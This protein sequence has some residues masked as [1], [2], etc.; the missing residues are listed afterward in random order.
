MRTGRRTILFPFLLLFFGGLALGQAADL[1]R[2]A[3]EIAAQA[4]ARLEEYRDLAGEIARRQQ[5]QVEKQVQGLRPEEESK[6]ERIIL[7]ITLGEAPDQEVEKNQRLLHGI[8]A[9]APD[10]VV[11]VRG[12]PA[13][14][15]HLEQFVLYLKKI[16]ESGKLP[17][18]RLDPALFR[19]Y[20]VSVAPTMI[21]E[22]DGK[23]VAEVRGL[24]NPDWLRR[25]VEA[26]RTGDL[27][28]MG[29]T[30]ALAERDLIEEL[31]ERL[32]AVDWDGKKEQAYARYWRRFRFVDLPEARED[33]RFTLDA[34]YTVPQDIILPD[35]TVAARQGQVF[36]LFRVLKPTF[37]LVIFDGAKPGHVAWA[38]EQAKEYQGKLRPRF[39]A[40]ALPDRDNGWQALENLEQQLQGPVYLLTE[41]VRDR[42]QVKHVP[43]VVTPGADHFEVREF[44]LAAQ[45]DR[46]NQH[47][48]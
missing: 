10:A 35:G 26:G 34:K 8:Q 44:C 2:L 25:Q 36:D 24:I 39:I 19:K 17:G 46:L 6:P 27:G 5:R 13:G 1:E 31:Q 14:Q 7:F 11:A 47:P 37:V 29:P 18:I 20:Q 43:A 48:K 28:Q 22:R 42:F 21:L 16:S 23:P 3:A 9:A 30:A 41:Q 40:T 32:M 12:L 4:P 15:R 45:A 38:R 33:R